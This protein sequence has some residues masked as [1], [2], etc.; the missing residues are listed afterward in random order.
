MDTGW[1]VS[2]IVV[3]IWMVIILGIMI[4]LERKHI[5]RKN[6]K[7][8]YHKTTIFLRWNVFDTLT[9]ALVIYTIICVQALNLLISSGQ[10][11]DNVYVQFF[12]NQSQAWT[13][14]A[15]IYLLMRLSNTLKSIRARYGGTLE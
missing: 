12:T 7:I 14:I 13:I 11:V 10:T 2:L 8:D 5:V 15:F 9:I 6:G 3:G 1:I 4:P